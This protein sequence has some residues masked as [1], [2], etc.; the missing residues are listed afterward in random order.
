M[1]KFLGLVI[2]VL[3]SS[4]AMAAQYDILVTGSTH[5][6]PGQAELASL[7]QKSILVD[8]TAKTV[9]LQLAPV[10]TAG[11]VCPEFI[12][13]VTLNM[14]QFSTNRSDELTT[15]YATGNLDLNGRPTQA[16]IQI[17]LNANNA[18]DISIINSSECKSTHSSFIGSPAVVSA[19]IF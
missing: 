4:Q 9:R 16:I 6:S 7:I 12:R 3:F 2:A 19:Q 11:A 10:C 5:V 8:T 1:N 18:M 15:V 13:N 17:S 14:T